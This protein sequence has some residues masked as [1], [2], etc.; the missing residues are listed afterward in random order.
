MEIQIVEVSVKDVKKLQEISC[1]TFI[2][3]FASKN[4]A[5]N[6]QF[7]LEHNYAEEKLSLELMNPESRFFFANKGAETV[8]YLKLNP[9]RRKRFYPISKG[10]K[11]KGSILT[12]IQKAKESE[13]CL[14]IFQ[15]GR[16]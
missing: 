1:R 5:E 7:F 3:T 9:G 4:T 12:R 6:M 16:Q 11:L 8:G 14:S 13:K 15:P 10:L 2:Q